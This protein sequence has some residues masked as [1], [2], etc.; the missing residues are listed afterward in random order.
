MSGSG[1]AATKL[2]V[3]SQKSEGVANCCETGLEGPSSY[4]VGRPMIW[5]RA[6]TQRAAIGTTVVLGV[7]IAVAAA[8]QEPDV[9]VITK[10]PTTIRP[11]VRGGRMAAP[12]LTPGD[13]AATEST[14]RSPQPIGTWA[15]QNGVW[16]AGIAPV[17]DV[18]NGSGP[19]G[20]ITPSP[21]AGWS[22]RDGAWVAPGSGDASGARTGA[23]ATDAVPGPSTPQ[24]GAL[25]CPAPAPGGDWTCQNGTWVRS[26]TPAP[27]PNNPA[28]ES[29][30]SSCPGPPPSSNAVCQAGVWIIR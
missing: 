30:N 22:C 12:A 21:G 26:T 27:R 9:L 24:S 19:G 6:R 2:E 11:G 29:P 17:S 3:G 1:G 28:N 18:P 14:C 16:V 13:S 20:C 25:Q 10:E 4:R 7:L 15:C 23:P 8:R 5:T